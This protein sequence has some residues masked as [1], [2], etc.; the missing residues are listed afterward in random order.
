[1]RQSTEHTNPAG[2]MLRRRI[3]LLVKS[4][5]DDDRGGPKPGI[6]SIMI[7][8]YTFWF[9]A[10]IVFQL[11]TGILHALILFISPE[12]N[13]ETGRQ[14]YSLLTSYKLNMGAGFNP[15]F[16]NIVTALSS[17]FS[18]LCL[19]AASTNGYLL[20][21][22]TEANVMKGIIGINVLI[23]GGVFA[24]MA[25]FTFLPPIIFTGLI[26]VNLLAAFVLIQKSGSA[27]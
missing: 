27:T 26:F 2:R 16:S 15:S 6:T 25:Y 14:L 23:F 11:V 22:F 3:S 10:A 4:G 21:K 12:P 24:M 17:S 20:F 5:K 1:M 7:R 19:F 18:F 8:R 9:S 13:D